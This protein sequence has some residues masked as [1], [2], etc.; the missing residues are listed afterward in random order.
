MNRRREHQY[1]PENSPGRPCSTE[2]DHRSPKLRRWT[3]AVHF[4]AGKHWTPTI[5]VTVESGSLAA[6]AAKAVRAAKVK[7]QQLSGRRLYGVT[8]KAEQVR[9]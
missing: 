5:A 2:C 8:V 4:L 6:V 1:T 7:Y 3:C 9:T